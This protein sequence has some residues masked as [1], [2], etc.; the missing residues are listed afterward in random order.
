MKS[1]LKKL[2]PNR[3]KPETELVENINEV[4][5]E[6]LRTEETRYTPVEPQ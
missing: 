6:N 2:L 1:I 5:P 3:E 4:K